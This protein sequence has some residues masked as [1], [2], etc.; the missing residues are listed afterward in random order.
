MKLTNKQKQQIEIVK[1]Y[2]RV[3]EQKDLDAWGEFWHQ[4]A[5]FLI[6]YAPEGF[7]NI[8]S[9]RDQIVNSFIAFLGLMRYTRNLNTCLLP[10]ASCLKTRKLCTS[11]V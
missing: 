10:P 3:Q 2:F 6:P 5:W 4:E 9:E 7:A 8:F 1:Q 11:Q